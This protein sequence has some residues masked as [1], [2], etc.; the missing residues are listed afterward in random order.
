MDLYSF[1]GNLKQLGVMDI[2]L[3]FLLFYAIFLGILRTENVKKIFGGKDQV[4][5][6]I[7]ISLSMFIVAYTPFGLLMGNYLTL[8]FG[9]SSTIIVGLLALILI[10]GMMGLNMSDLTG[11]HQ[12]L[13]MSIVIVVAILIWAVAGP[14]FSAGIGGETLWTL[15]LIAA[16]IYLVMWASEGK[17][18]PPAGGAGAGAGGT[19]PAG[20]EKED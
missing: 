2:L 9:G 15:V 7:S 17:T 4:L 13:A 14:G 19:P 20:T 5:Q 10:A 8:V 6:I 12:K 18:T 1:M 11:G 3:P 16:I